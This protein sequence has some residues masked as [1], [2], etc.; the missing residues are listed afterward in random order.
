L[1]GK[2]P[3]APHDNLKSNYGIGK[4]LKFYINNIN[5]GLGAM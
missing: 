2:K 1:A 5:F 4:P 3:C